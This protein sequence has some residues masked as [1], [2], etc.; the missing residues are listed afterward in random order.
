LRREVK[1]TERKEKRN[2]HRKARLYRSPAKVKAGMSSRPILISTQDV[3]H[4]KVTN[5]AWSAERSWEELFLNISA[6][7]KKIEKGI[8]THKSTP[9]YPLWL[10]IPQGAC[11]SCGFM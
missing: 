11:R 8:E 3:D 6:P 9:T 7:P 2:K 4:R 5:S 1:R 10:F